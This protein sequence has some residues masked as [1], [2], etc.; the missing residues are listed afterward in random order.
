MEGIKTS[1]LSENEAIKIGEFVSYME[2][3]T[4]LLYLDFRKFEDI[5]SEYKDKEQIISSSALRIS[6]ILSHFK[7]VRSE[8]DISVLVQTK[9]IL[10]LYSNYPLSSIIQDSIVCITE[11]DSYK[12]V[13]N[14]FKTIRKKKTCYTGDI[15][16]PSFFGGAEDLTKVYASSSTIVK[17]SS[18]LMSATSTNN[19]SELL[20]YNYVTNDS[21]S[22]VHLLNLCGFENFYIEIYA[23]SSIVKPI[24]KLNYVSK[25]GD[26]INARFRIY[27]ETELTNSSV[28]SK[29]AFMIYTTVDL[30]SAIKFSTNDINGDASVKEYVN[31]LIPELKTACQTLKEFDEKIKFIEACNKFGIYI[32]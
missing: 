6:Q 14:R 29:Y 21:I 10:Y 1:Y 17:L 9:D 11:Q 18:S 23:N 16:K 19:S 15:L 20:P 24:V 8:G 3:S 13:M 5:L 27:L 30:E 26:D 28:S 32:K 31:S 25:S 22:F 7:F 4:F 2:S 12:T